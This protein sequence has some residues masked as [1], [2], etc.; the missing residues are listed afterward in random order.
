MPVHSGLRWLYDTSPQPHLAIPAT[1]ARVYRRRIPLATACACGCKQQHTLAVSKV[2][3][4][5]DL[6]SPTGRVLWFATW[7]CKAA[8]ERQNV[9][10]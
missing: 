9:R 2:I 6:H 1:R 3:A 5:D 7:Y 10:E 8:W 4:E